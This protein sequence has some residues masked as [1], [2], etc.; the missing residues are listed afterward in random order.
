MKDKN[1]VKIG[2]LLGGLSSE[3]EVSLMTGEAIYAALVNLNYEVH[4]IDP[5]LDDL[6]EKSKKVDII[7]NALHGR[8][9][10][11]GLIQGFLE[12]INKPYTGSPVVSSSITMNKVFTKQILSFYQ[13]PVIKFKEISV[14]D[15]LDDVKFDFPMVVKPANEGSSV[16]I[17]IV[18]NENNLIVDVKKGLEAYGELLV[19]PYIKGQEVQVA[20]L[21]G[22][23]LG[24]VEIQPENEFYDYDAKYVS[25]GTKYFTPANVSDVVNNKLYEYSEKINKILKCNGVVRIDYIVQNEDIFLLEVNTLPGMTNSSLVPKIARNKGISFD[26]LIDKIVSSARVHGL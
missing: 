15:D 8:F 24:T 1:K 10:E 5:K 7:F 3:R 26:E 6:Y 19:E 23:V 9:G 4:K 20:V 11:D 25:H 14:L 18:K 17:S 16:G 12:T 2:L 13:I 21:N 22:D